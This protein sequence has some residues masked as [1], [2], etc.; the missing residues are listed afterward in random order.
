MVAELFVPSFGALGVGGIASFI[1]GSLL[2]Y[3]PTVGSLPLATILPTAIGFGLAMI[4]LGYLAM[5]T[6][7]IKSKHNTPLGETAE[8]VQV[9]TA[10]SGTSGKVEVR[11]EIWNFVSADVL[12]LHDQVKIDKVDGLKLFVSRSQADSS[13]R[14]S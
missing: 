14:S 11:G 6:R 3:D 9:Q 12:S 1:A 2:L 13:S 8:V 10:A 5:Q 7:H 4:G